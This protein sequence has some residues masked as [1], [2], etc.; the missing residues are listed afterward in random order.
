MHINICIYMYAHTHAQHTHILLTMHTH[1]Y[2]HMHMYTKIDMPVYR[3]NMH[4]YI[5]NH[6]VIY[7]YNRPLCNTEPLHNQK[8]VYNL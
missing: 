5:C 3:A 8:S 1:M 6:I 4:T 2:T 7:V